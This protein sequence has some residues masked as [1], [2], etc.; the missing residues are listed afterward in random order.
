[1]RGGSGAEVGGAGFARYGDASERRGGGDAG[2]GRGRQARLDGLR[3]WGLGMCGKLLR[4]PAVGG[5]EFEG[6]DADVVD[7]EQGQGRLISGL[8]IGGLRVAE[9]GD[10]LLAGRGWSG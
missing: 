5:C 4:Q 7:A 9:V 1:M 6:G 10:W 2:A 8:L 3:G